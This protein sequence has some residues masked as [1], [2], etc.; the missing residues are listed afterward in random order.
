MEE[1][2]NSLRVD[3]FLHWHCL[4]W[5]MNLIQF[6]VGNM[7]K[8]KTYL[9]QETS[10]LMSLHCTCKHNGKKQVTGTG[11]IPLSTKK[12]Q[13]S[14]LV[15]SEKHVFDSGN[16][17]RELMRNCFLNVFSWRWYLSR[18]MLILNLEL[19]AQISDWKYCRFHDICLICFFF[20]PS[21]LK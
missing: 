7:V 4:K 14:T 20:F 10:G 16:L 17:A 15:Y 5:K 11:I 12:I 1:Y 13:S 18:K 9:F 6:Q 19:Y 3:A 21:G 2:I 8:V